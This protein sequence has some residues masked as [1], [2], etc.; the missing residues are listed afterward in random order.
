RL[1]AIRSQEDFD[2]IVKTA[3][4]S[5]DID[6]SQHT[7]LIGVEALNTGYSGIT[8]QLRK[9]TKGGQDG[10]ELTISF[11]LNAAT[12]MSEPTWH[13]LIPKHLEHIPVKIYIEKE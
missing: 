12:V 7:L 1:F 9:I 13:I 11:Q 8:Y 4:C 2:Q 10:L 6:F 5:P 3:T